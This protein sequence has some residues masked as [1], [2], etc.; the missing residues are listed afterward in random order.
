M[1]DFWALIPA[2]RASTRLPDK[3]LADIGGKPMVVRVAERAAKSGAGRIVVATD[4]KEIFTQVNAHGFEVV[5]TSAA[6]ASGTDRIAE[7]SELLKASEN[8][9]LV[10]VQGDEPLIDPGLIASVAQSLLNS[11]SAAVATAAHP[12]HEPHAIASP[13]VVKVVCNERSEALYFS[14]APIAYHRDQWPELG[15]IE[16][17]NSRAAVLRHIGIYGFRA[18]ALP[19]FVRWGPCDLE[20]I[21]QLEQLRWL[22]HGKTIA[23]HQTAHAPAPGVDTAQDLERVREIWASG[24][25]QG[26]L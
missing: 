21:E 2:R 4:C 12:I 22:W 16:A 11:S 8:Q 19:N 10:N 5:L 14:R 24:T 13:N 20:R 6:H 15:A 9:V 17:G 26:S 7:A 1:P 25:P 23:V 18:Q 3:A